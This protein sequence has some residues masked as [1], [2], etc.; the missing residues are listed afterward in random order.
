MS[1]HVI[2][3]TDD[4]FEAEVLQADKP[5]LVDFW[6]EWCG[7][8]KM[9]SPIVD[10]VATARAETLK[11]VKVNVDQ[12]PETPGKYG[13]RGIPTLL[14]FKEGEVVATKVGAVSRSQLESFID[15]SL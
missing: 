15:E 7:P 8:C 9:I 12:C 6:A 3:S 5:V 2:N 13:V 10:E 11:V 1:E 14:L 4:Q